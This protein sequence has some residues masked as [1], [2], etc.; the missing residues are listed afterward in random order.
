M[1]HMA[2]REPGWPTPAASKPSEGF[3]RLG[4]ADGMGTVCV[5]HVRT[6]RS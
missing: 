1:V 3:E 6:V 2:V 5:S 4:W